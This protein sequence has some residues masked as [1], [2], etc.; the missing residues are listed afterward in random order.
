M[1]LAENGATN[2]SIVIASDAPEP[3][4][5]AASELSTFLGQMTGAEFAV[6]RDDAAPSNFEIVLGETKRKSLADVP[7]EL[8][9]KA[10][11]GFVLLREDERLYIIGGR[12][13]RGT[14]YGVYDFLEQDLA[15]RFLADDVNHVPKR[16]TLKVAVRS[17]FYDPPFEYRALQGS[18]DALARNR[19]NSIAQGF[20]NVVRLGTKIHTFAHLVPAGKYF[21]D[22]P[23]YFALIDGK[24]RARTLCLTNPDT[25]RITIQTARQW[26]E[27]AGDDPGMIYIVPVHQN[28]SGA[29]CRCEN[30]AAVDQ[31][32]GAPMT[33]ALI[34]FVNAVARA[35]A[36]DFPNVYIETMAYNTSEVPPKKVKPDPNVVVWLGVIVKDHGKALDVPQ[37]TYD[38]KQLGKELLQRTSTIP[39]RF[40]AT[41]TY[42][43]LRG[44]GR[45]CR[46]LYIWDYDQSFHDYLVPYPSLFSN[47]ENIRIFAESGA[48]GYMAQQPNQP[49]GEMRHLRNYVLARHLWRPELDERKTVEE[50]CCLYYGRKAGGQILEYVD[51]LHDSWARQD[52]P[53][54]WGGYKDDRFVR[55]ADKILRKAHAL[56]QTQEQRQRV[57]RFRMPIWRL[58]ITQ[59]FGEAGRVTSLPEQW[60]HRTDD[61]TKAQEQEWHETTDFTGW[62]QVK[63]PT[64]LFYSGSGLG[65]GWYGVAFDMPEAGAPLALHFHAMNGSWE[66][67]VDGKQVASQMPSGLGYYHEVPYVPLPEGLA[68]GRHTLIVRVRDGSG[69]YKLL[70]HENPDFTT[71]D[72]VT[73]VDMSK[74]LS[75]ELRAAAEG[76]LSA[77]REV[78]LIRVFYGYSNPEP[79]L[80]QLLRPKIG[81]LL[82]HGG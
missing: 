21:A 63:I 80:E 52:R 54:W 49:G 46:N 16:T 30:C 3:V 31:E 22:H 40:K 60:W 23:E 59:A 41:R 70:Q 34:R 37:V 72:P 14:L 24:R 78:G 6:L 76:F 68:P 73:I 36:P 11:E 5:K 67:Y 65:A 1:L 2:Y 55:A 33:G 56:A 26:A 74:P 57:A 15:V 64:R 44:W 9:P 81:F 48:T 62:K 82:T 18:S 77:S 20:G 13:P 58:M 75:P 12:I 61:G 27:Q 17:R 4:E 39:D 43:N 7:S 69:F 8:Q 32:E 42:D 47:C 51:L 25:L 29:Y 28:D 35:L 45:I 10:W 66:V 50:F 53:L 38:E 79:Y 19:I 71:A